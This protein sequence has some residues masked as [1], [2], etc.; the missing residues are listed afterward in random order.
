MMRIGLAV[1][2]SEHE[3]PAPAGHPENTKRLALTLEE[4]RKPAWREKFVELPVREYP[5]S[6]IEAVHDTA[7]LDY[8]ASIGNEGWTHIDPDTY[9][10]RTSFE[11][12]CRVTWSLLSA[13][14]AAFGG[15]P[16]VSFVIGRPPGHHAERNR[17]MGFCLV[18]HVAVATQYALD[19]L[20]AARVAV[21]DF[22]VHHGNGTQAIFYD[23][24]DVLYISTHQYP[25]Y[26]GTG[27]MM[28]TGRDEGEGYTLNI[29]LP[30]GTGDNDILHK[31]EG[32]ILPALHEFNPDLI[33]VS[34]GFDGHRF[35]PLGGF[36]LTG[37]GYGQ[38]ARHLKSATSDLCEGR[39]IS[40]MEGGYDPEGNLDSITHYLKELTS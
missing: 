9:A 6:V 20:D 28:E 15:G 25:F 10:G 34:A 4:L 35:D 8:L 33:L 7:H 2:P 31:F 3:H 29:P 36:R 11:A 1:I 40:L 27:A 16:S 19:A 26:P 30:A 23:R 17:S 21:V 12:S 18:N 13:V 14:D 22:D 38:I 24:S 39:L 37:E 5:R 32:N